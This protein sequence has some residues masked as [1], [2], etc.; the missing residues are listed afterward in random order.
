MCVAS[1][2]R[3][4]FPRGLVQPEGALR[5]SMDALLLARFA[6]LEP[7]CRFAD[8][9]TGCGI[10][11]CALALNHADVTGV[12]LERE[13]CLVAAARQNF[14]NLNLEARLTCVEGDA[15]EATC[16][17]RLGTGS[18]DTVVLNPPYYVCG[19]GRPSPRALR[20]RGLEGAADSLNI[21]FAAAARLLRHH[22]HMACI[23]P[24][25]RMGDAVLLLRKHKLGL[26]RICCVHSREGKAAKRV[27]LEARAHATEDI[28]IE[29]PLT[30][31]TQLQV[32]G[33]APLALQP[34][35]G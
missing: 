3:Q 7:G 6:T 30:L 21:F 11:A 1:Y 20:R 24:A 29:A 23:L 9:G 35:N 17:K 34:K 27:L 32:A 25:A 5:A 14:A 19:Q 16:L 2:F 13:G 33:Q 28:R 31:H 15:G 12:G 8:L 22:G 26:R 18:F 4:V 10:V